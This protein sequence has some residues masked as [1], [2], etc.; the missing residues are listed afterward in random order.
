VV[1]NPSQTRPAT[2]TIANARGQ[3]HQAV[4]DPGAVLEIF[5][6]RAGL[7]P[8]SIDYTSKTPSAYRLTSN[9][10]IVAY[11]FNPLDNVGVFSNDGSLLIPEHAYD[12]IYYVMTMP[13]LS[14]RE[15]EGQNHD[16]NGYMTIVASKPGTTEI[17]FI[18]PAEVRAGLGIPALPA[19]TEHTFT[20]EQYDVL[21]LE[22]VSGADLTGT[23]IESVDGTTDFG[24]FIGHEAMVVTDRGFPD[25]CC[26]D[27]LEEQ[28]FPASTWGNDYAIAR[29]KPRNHAPRGSAAPDQLLIL[30]QKRD[31]RV[32]FDPEPMTHN[33]GV[34]PA[35]GYCDAF[36]T[37]DTRV[38]SDQPLLVGHLLLSAGGP[39][40]APTPGDPALS[41]AVPFEQFRLDYTFLVPAAYD[42]SFISVVAPFGGSVLLNGAEKGPEMTQFA[43]AFGGGRFPVSPGQH[44]L[45]CPDGCGVL[46]HGYSEA[47]SYMFAG[48]LDLARIT[49]P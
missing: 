4:V 20:L 46:V 48:G 16:Y 40:G 29:T 47:V 5:P 38:S 3:S 32:T 8:A 36:I 28:L 45:E 2:V 11:Q 24:V 27:H 42:A 18:S 23:R 9:E 6:N 30:A 33:C 17:K 34:L 37:Q 12:T 10:P 15:G 1:S 19:F 35:G 13:T 22:S 21:N 14:R 31:T 49:V 41:F 7:D 39:R 25:L 44:R 43:A 26:A